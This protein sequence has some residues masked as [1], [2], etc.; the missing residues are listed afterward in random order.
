[1]SFTFKN[2]YVWEW[3]AN[4]KFSPNWVCAQRATAKINPGSDP[5][6]CC[7]LLLCDNLFLNLELWWT[8]QA[9]S[10]NCYFS[11]ISETS[12]VNNSF[13]RTLKIDCE[14]IILWINIILKFKNIIYSFNLIAEKII[15]QLKWHSTLSYCSLT[16]PKDFSS[17][18]NCSFSM[19]C[20]CK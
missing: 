16:Y 11:F 1:M 14:I 3:V 17:R 2:E 4:H 5:E 15:F 13:E 19:N 7:S 10:N 8:E 9:S 18:I 20:F 6:T 12:K